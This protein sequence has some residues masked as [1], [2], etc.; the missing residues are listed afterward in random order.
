MS[1]VDRPGEAT[2]W[3]ERMSQR[4][5]ARQAARE[6]TERERLRQQYA[7]LVAAMPPLPGETRIGLDSIETD[8]VG[9]LTHWCASEQ[10]G[11]CSCG[12]AIA[13]ICVTG[14]ANPPSCDIC[15][16]RQIGEFAQVARMPPAHSP[17]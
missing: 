3:E 13:V 17:H 5:K 2:T 8:H 12:A 10:C 14:V 7:H 1:D 11:M 16:A 9:H 15:R 6:E 4:A